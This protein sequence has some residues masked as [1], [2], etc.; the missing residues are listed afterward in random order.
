MFIRV[1]DSVHVC[2]FVLMWI[3]VCAC[4]YAC[5]SACACWYVCESL[6]VC[7][8]HYVLMVWY[9]FWRPR[10][11][12]HVYIN[13]VFASALVCMLPCVF[14]V[15]TCECFSACAGLR[16]PGGPR[17]LGNVFFWGPWP[18]TWNFVSWF[19]WRVQERG[20]GGIFGANLVSFL[21]ILQGKILQ[22]LASAFEVLFPLIWNEFLMDFDTKIA[23]SWDATLT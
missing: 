20:S 14:F 7:D 11:E 5:A 16:R 1:W 4:A 3:S 22:K 8:G 23:A 13:A 9:W 21:D 15:Q 18:A 12:M 19:K 2:M 17:V 6:H 10:A